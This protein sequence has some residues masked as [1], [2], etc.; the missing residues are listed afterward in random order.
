MK[1]YAIYGLIALGI[2]ISLCVFGIPAHGAELH[3]PEIEPMIY[4]ISAD[5]RFN[6]I[7]ASNETIDLMGMLKGTI[8]PFTDLFGEAFL[9]I[10][11]L[12]FL[13]LVYFRSQN[14]TFL[15]VTVGVTAFW[16]GAHLPEYSLI[17]LAL[18]LLTGI[19]A[20]LYRLF[21]R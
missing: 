8:S 16:W 3:I 2:V 1:K 18:I 11:Y 19:S 10:V 6:F 17:G 9:L 15:A 20:V 21:R 12:V 7:D 5:E 4:D 13:M 14:I